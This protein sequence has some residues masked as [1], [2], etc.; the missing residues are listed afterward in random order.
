MKKVNIGVV[1]LGMLGDVHINQLQNE[2]GSANVIA[3][4]DI[5]E[6]R[7]KEI[8]EKYDIPNGYTDYDEMLKNKDIDAVFIITN[9]QAHKEQ[10]IKACEA[11]LHIFCEKPLALDLNDCKEIEKAVEA[12]NT[13]LFTLG[14]MRRFDPS[15]ADAKKRVDA[16]EIGDVIMF[17]STS[18]D[19]ADTLKVNVPKA[20][21]G[22]FHPWFFEMGIHDSDLTRWFLGS[23]VKEAYATGGC[24]VA[25]ELAQVDDYD[26]G[27]AL[28]TFENGSCAYIHVGKTAPSCHVEAEII[29]TKGTLK[30]NPTPRRNRVELY[31]DGARSEELIYD[32]YE[33]WAEAFRLEKVDF[34]QCILEGKQPSISVY[35]GTKSLELATLLHKS[36]MEKVLVKAK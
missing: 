9:V 35:D 30:V 33:R 10:I 11:K 3:V 26:N 13:K 34:L 23:E 31:K 27:F 7:V 8:Q 36:Y 21:A 22:A 29:G 12:N 5:F 1:G 16:G 18:L 19:A 32:F 28:A 2:I 6:K 14:F 15:Y 20:L 24:Y 17:K 4:C 25:P